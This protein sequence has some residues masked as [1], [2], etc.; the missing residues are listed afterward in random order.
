LR[1]F[2]R[3]LLIEYSGQYLDPSLKNIWI[4]INAQRIIGVHA[5]DKTPIP[6]RDQAIMV[7][8]AVKDTV[9]RML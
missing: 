5:K 7:I 8:F 4:L 1:N 9:T 6:S 3:E 2:G